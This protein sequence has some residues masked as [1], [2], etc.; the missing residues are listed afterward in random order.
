VLRDRD[1]QQVEE[2]TLV[3]RRLPAGNEEIEVFAETQPAHEIGGQVASAHL[4]A[5][6]RRRGNGR[7]G[8]PGLADQ[9][10]PS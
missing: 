6:C 9:H 8:R 10:I 3:L 7:H 2:E 1:Q 5:V 4:D